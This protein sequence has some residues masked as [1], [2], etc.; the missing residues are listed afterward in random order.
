MPL[1]AVACYFYLYFLEPETS[2]L[3]TGDR[4]DDDYAAAESNKIAD[5]FYKY[6]SGLDCKLKINSR[7]T[8][9]LFSF[10]GRM[11]QN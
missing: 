5:I 4:V 11:E 9:L 6:V 7:L 1:T 8:P 3:A 2:R 10:K